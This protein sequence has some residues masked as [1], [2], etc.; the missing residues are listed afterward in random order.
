MASRPVAAAA[1]AS[2]EGHGGLPGFPSGMG[3]G[4]SDGADAGTMRPAGGGV[5]P[6][7]G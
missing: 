1:E 7:K 3:C 6:P 4:D 5:Y 2:L